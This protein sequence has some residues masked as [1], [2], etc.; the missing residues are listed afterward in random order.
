MKCGY[1]GDDAIVLF[2]CNFLKG[3]PPFPKSVFPV[4]GSRPFYQDALS[5]VFFFCMANE[6]VGSANETK[7]FPQ[8]VEISKKYGNDAQFLI[9][10][11]RKNI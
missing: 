7:T 8:D 1:C 4:E 6:K 11:I 2:K 5:K 10:C 3:V 9:V